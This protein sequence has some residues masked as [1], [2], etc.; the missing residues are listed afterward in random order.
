MKE[1]D[2]QSLFTKWVKNHK[3]YF[4]CS[5]SFEL[6]IVNTVKKKSIRFDA[7]AKHQLEALDETIRDGFYYKIPDMTAMNHFSSPKP[8]DC[9][10]IKGL[11]YVVILFYKPRKDKI[12]HLIPVNNWKSIEKDFPRKSIREE[13]IEPYSIKINL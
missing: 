6:K 5:C 13:E 9:F 8:F 3:D 2:F 4:G 1:K 10:L 7:V 11:A 12:V